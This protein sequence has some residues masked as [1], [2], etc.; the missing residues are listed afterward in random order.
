MQEFIF[1]IILA[2]ID[3]SRKWENRVI[4]VK[5]LLFCFYKMTYNEIW[6]LRIIAC[7]W[8]KLVKWEYSLEKWGFT[9]YVHIQLVCHTIENSSYFT[10]FA[11]QEKKSWQLSQMSTL[12]A[13][14][15]LPVMPAVACCLNHVS[16]SGQRSFPSALIQY[17]VA[18]LL[19]C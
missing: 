5:Y 13:R 6:W 19:E 14:T 1:L 16:S 4:L 8:K 2:P 9:L 18:G 10:T 7:R 15:P 17:L 12:H 3:D 11:P